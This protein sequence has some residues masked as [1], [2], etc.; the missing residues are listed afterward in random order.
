MMKYF[1]VGIWI[2]IVALG[3]TF[4]AA[5]MLGGS[6]PGAAEAAGASLSSGSWPPA[7][8]APTPR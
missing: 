3:S 6:K 8:P 1:L 2:T 4:G 7:R 5:M